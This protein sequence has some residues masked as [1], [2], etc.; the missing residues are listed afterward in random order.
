M[1][2]ENRVPDIVLSFH[3][4]EGIYDFANS[5]HNTTEQ[6]F[7]PLYNNAI[8]CGLFTNSRTI[9][10]TAVVQST[11]YNDSSS[12]INIENQGSILF[13]ANNPVVKIG[14][15]YVWVNGTYDFP[16]TSCS[17][18]YTGKKGTV[19]IIASILRERQ[20]KIYFD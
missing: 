5:T 3:R 18:K 6:F 1:A 19:Q 16:I 11:Y 14:N 15:N 8:H 13:E 17:G 10:N 2:L 12:V 4:S 20:I 9:F 7:V